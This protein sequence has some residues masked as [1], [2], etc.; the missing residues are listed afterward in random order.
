MASVLPAAERK[1][2]RRAVHTRC[3]V[4]TE[5]G[6]RLVG[7]RTWDVSEDGM[8]VPMEVPVALGERLLVALEAPGTRI[9]VD[10]EARVAR[11]VRG[12]RHRDRGAS[13]GI[14]FERMDAP[15]RAVLRASLGGLPPPVPARRAR[16]DYAASVGLY[17]A[18]L[19]A[20]PRLPRPRG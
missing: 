19:D 6:F 12:R 3:Q 5:Q 4:V 20:D 13:V 17:R 14:V 11:L 7:S 9:W 2:P 1:S 18:G 10:A 15:S 16:R 8:L